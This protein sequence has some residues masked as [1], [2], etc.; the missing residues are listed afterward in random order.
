MVMSTSQLRVEYAP[1]CKEQAV[2]GAQEAWDAL[3][4]W[5]EYYNY[6]LRAADT[7]SRSCRKITGGSGWSL[8]AFFIAC[9]I[10]L[11]NLGKVI[12]G[13]VACDFN[14]QSNP[15]GSRLITDMLI[16]KDGVL[17]PDAIEGIR[18][19]SGAQVFRWGGYYRGNK[20]AMHYEIVCSR[21]ALASG[22]NPKTLPPSAAPTPIPEPEEEPEVI[23]YI[24]CKDNRN[25]W[26]EI[27]G[28]LFKTNGLRNGTE[29]IL[30]DGH[31]KRLGQ[32]ELADADNATAESP[33]FLNELL[34]ADELRRMGLKRPT[35]ETHPDLDSAKYVKD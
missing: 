9:V 17:M 20:D 13:G 6:K 31:G 19:N 28:K 29:W 1:N 35:P 34:S 2:P 32:L 10:L 33:N 16:R 15:Y 25:E 27:K 26:P 11:W 22:I 18:T 24:Y 8:H 4:A 5:M 3:I 14:W 12:K 30:T 23:R 21:A 7:G